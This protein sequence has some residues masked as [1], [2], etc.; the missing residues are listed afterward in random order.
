MDEYQ[1]WHRA[2]E[3]YKHVADVVANDPQMAALKTQHGLLSA[4][5]QDAEGVTP[6]P[7]EHR[8]TELGDI[9]LDPDGQEHKFSAMT[10]EGQHGTVAGF[11]PTHELRHQLYDEWLNDREQ[12]DLHDRSVDYADRDSP[13]LLEQFVGAAR[14]DTPTPKPSDYRRALQVAIG[15]A[16]HRDTDKDRG[17]TV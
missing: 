6:L 14:R 4:R 15:Q 3:A 2:G 13:A 1:V 11:E 5:W 7:G 16:K 17:L 9:I 12:R 8:S 10:P